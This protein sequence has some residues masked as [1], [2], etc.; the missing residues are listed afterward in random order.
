MVSATVCCMLSVFP[1]AAG[2]HSFR[3]ARSLCFRRGFASRSR[4]CVVPVRAPE[5]PSRVTRWCAR[6]AFSDQQGNGDRIE[7]FTDR[8]PIAARVVL[9]IDGL[10]GEC[11]DE[12]T[13]P[14]ASG[15]SNAGVLPDVA[16]NRPMPTRGPIERQL[17]AP[18][19][20]SAVSEQALLDGKYSHDDRAVTR[21]DGGLGRHLTRAPWPP[22]ETSDDESERLLR[23][24]TALFTRALGAAN[25]A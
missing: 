20:L 24:L 17:G 25:R 10:P 23:D 11:V 7:D 8:K 19:P 18:V 13:S 12:I 2:P 6:R 9:Q 15:K 1:R 14:D 16:P 3:A 21:D 5:G 22:S 4:S